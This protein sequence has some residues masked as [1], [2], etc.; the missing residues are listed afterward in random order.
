MKQILSFLF[1][2]I[3]IF[4]MAN[5]PNAVKVEKSEGGFDIFFVAD[6]PSIKF[7]STEI[8]ISSENSITITYDKSET[9]NISF[10]YAESSIDNVLCDNIYK[11]TANGIEIISKP[12]SKIE[13]YSPTGTLLFSATTDDNGSLYVDMSQLNPGVNILICNNSKFK[14]IR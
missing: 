4:L 14:F 3:P 11:M 10:V 6:T 13:I 2:L 9:L 7:T 1:L 5:N 8:V 12:H